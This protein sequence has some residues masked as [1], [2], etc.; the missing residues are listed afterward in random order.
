MKPS[1]SFT[2]FVTIIINII[3]W[4]HNPDCRTACWR[5][6]CACWI[7][8]GLPVIVINLSLVPGIGSESIFIDAPDSCRTWE[9]FEPLAPITIPKNK[10]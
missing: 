6:N 10:I 9:I 5:R 7:W 8:F 4:F 1:V 3:Y 2:G